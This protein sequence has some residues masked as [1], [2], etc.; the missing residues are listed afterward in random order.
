MMCLGHAMGQLYHGGVRLAV[1]AFLGSEDTGHL[2]LISIDLNGTTVPSRRIP[3][4]LSPAAGRLH[5]AVA[6]VLSLLRPGWAEGYGSLGR[7][8][9]DAQG[10]FH[11]VGTELGPGG[12]GFRTR[13]SPDFL[14][15]RGEE[16]A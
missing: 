7:V 4:E 9:V 16:P 6:T 8:V 3:Q 1:F 10:Q 14:A 11:L 15:P 13:C 5:L 2:H 12:K